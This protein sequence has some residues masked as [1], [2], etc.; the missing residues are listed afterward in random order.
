MKRREQLAALIAF[1][2]GA[3]LVFV[4]ATAMMD[5][6]TRR[7]ETVFRAVLG[8]ER[9]DELMAGEGGFPHYL[10]SS[11]SAPEIELQDREGQPWRLADHRGKVVV[12][13]FWSI[14]CPPCL[15][16]LPS[17]ELLAHLAERWGDVE[18]V[19]VSADE[20]W[21][22]VSSVVPP[23]TRLTHVFDPTREAITG[24]FGTRLFPETWIIDREGRV[25]FRYDGALDWGNPIVV[26][27]VEAYR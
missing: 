14:T 12:L 27:L 4:Y 21:S 17:L 10:G 5:G 23:D 18:V 19:A 22:A 16:E 9:F 24:Q 26:E 11:L 3:P 2:L 6:D 20:G 1:L 13:N 15:E 8:N 25:R 7:R